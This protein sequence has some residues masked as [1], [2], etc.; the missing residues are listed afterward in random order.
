MPALTA[1]PFSCVVLAEPPSCRRL[2]ISGSMKAPSVSQP[3]TEI[4]T[5]TRPRLVGRTRVIRR[6]PDYSTAPLPTL[7]F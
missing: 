1:G 7:T 5:C 3:H 4:E 2:G 6:N